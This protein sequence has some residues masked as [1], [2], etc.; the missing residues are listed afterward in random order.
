MN[1]AELEYQTAL[2]EAADIVQCLAHNGRDSYDIVKEAADR[3]LINSYPCILA[4]L[5]LETA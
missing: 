2:L 5:R 1:D 4:G 3:W